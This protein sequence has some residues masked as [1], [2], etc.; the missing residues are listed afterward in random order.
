M[1]K[2]YQQLDSLRGIA[3]LSVVISHFSQIAPTQW[4]ARM[5]W[6][7]FAEGHSAVILFFALSGFVLTL[8]MSGQNKPT[9]A[10]FVLKRMCRIYVPYLAAVVLAFAAYLHFYHGDLNW[11]GD[12]A[13]TRWQPGLGW[14]QF[15]QHVVFLWPFDNSTV[16]PVLWSLVYEMRISLLFPVLMLAIYQFPVPLTLIVSAALSLMVFGVEI[17][18]QRDLMDASVNGEWLP[19]LHYASMF[20]VGG[21]IARFRRKITA[22]VSAQHP[23]ALL[24][25]LVACI[26]VYALARG[27]DSRLFGNGVVRRFADDWLATCAVA[28]ILVL[29]IAYE[30]YARALSIRPLAFLGKIS[31]SLYLLHGIVLLASIHYFGAANPQASLWIAALLILPVSIAGYYLIESPSIRLG[32]FMTKRKASRTERIAKSF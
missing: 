28:G 30:P 3:A 22:R 6:R 29:A 13:N 1:T 12:W 2:R 15:I 16:D 20:V 7:V 21:L 17:H 9:F 31:Y 18:A 14:T 27:I 5:P 8:Q 19:T 26:G 23:R 24:G 25:V 10:E 11:A 32:R 4:L